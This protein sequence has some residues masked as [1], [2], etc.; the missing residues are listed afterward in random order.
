M[1]HNGFIGSMF[2]TLILS[3]F[4]MGQIIPKDTSSKPVVTVAVVDSSL[5]KSL[6]VRS[7]YW[8]E[9][10]VKDS[11]NAVNSRRRNLIAINALV[12]KP[13][14]TVKV[15]IPMPLAQEDKVPASDY[16]ANVSD[17][18]KPKAKNKTDMRRFFQR[19]GRLF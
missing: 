16:F 18:I 4:G 14:E 7:K 17:T 8:A 3:L 9:Q 11:I 2:F 15:Y 5:L 19:V 10:K 12:N 6:M 1:I 13:Q